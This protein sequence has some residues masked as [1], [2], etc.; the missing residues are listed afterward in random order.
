MTDR[1]IERPERSSSQALRSEK[2][3][4]VATKSFAS[5]SVP[6]FAGVNPLRATRHNSLILLD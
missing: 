6:K 3:E 1:Q 2:D 4:E 5:Q